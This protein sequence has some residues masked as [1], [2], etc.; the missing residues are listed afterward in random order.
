MR[1]N[2][3]ILKLIQ[4]MDRAMDMKLL[5]RQGWERYA[6]R[7]ESLAEHSF[8]SAICA[9]LL[10]DRESQ[11]V[12]AE[13]FSKEQ[14]VLHALIHDLPFWVV[15]MFSPVSVVPAFPIL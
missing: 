8:G 6:N 7:S 3:G 15:A 5:K 14:V 12:D 10:A 1:E 11:L 2:E 4:F 13:D 9:L